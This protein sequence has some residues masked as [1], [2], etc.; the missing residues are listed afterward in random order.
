MELPLTVQ[1][2][3]YLPLVVVQSLE[4]SSNVKTVLKYSFRLSAISL[5]FDMTAPLL[6]FNGQVALSSKHFLIVVMYVQ[7]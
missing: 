6:P 3:F 5:L 2:M 4:V 1:D 7:L